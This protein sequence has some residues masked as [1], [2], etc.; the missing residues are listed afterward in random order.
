[1]KRL[2]LVATATAAVAAG[3][4]F[5]SASGAP[6]GSGLT[7]NGQGTL[8]TIQATDSVDLRNLDVNQSSAVCVTDDVVPKKKAG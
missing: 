5:S 1:M 2:M 8:Y 6:P 4:A 3:F 7:C